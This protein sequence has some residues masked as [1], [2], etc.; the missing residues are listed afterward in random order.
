MLYVNVMY[1]FKTSMNVPVTLVNMTEHVRI[2]ST[3]IYVS[4]NLGI[5]EYTVK[6]VQQYEYVVKILLL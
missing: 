6:Q 1:L 4:V 5:Q 3:V 2:V